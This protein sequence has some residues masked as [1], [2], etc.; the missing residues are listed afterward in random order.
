MLLSEFKLLNVTNE[1]ECQ[2]GAAM[3]ERDM[4]VKKAQDTVVTIF[5]DSQRIKHCNW[6]ERLSTF[7]MSDKQ[8]SGFD[9]LGR[10]WR[11][12]LQCTNQTCNG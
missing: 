5:E 2:A 10:G 1:M 3:G 11:N 4:D 9:C 7:H 12:K 8:R 6:S